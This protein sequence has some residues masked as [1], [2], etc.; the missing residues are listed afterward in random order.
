[1]RISRARTLA[2]L[3][4]DYGLSRRTLLRRLPSLL[5]A[6]AE[7]GGTN[8]VP[9]MWM[10]GKKWLVNVSLLRRSHPEAFEWPS[11]DELDHRVTR[12]ERQV[13]ALDA[14]HRA[15]VKRLESKT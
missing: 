2:E 6:D 13:E 15:L 14:A 3:A 5:R 8:F 4:E 12:L 11:T 9:W 1:M 10:V 7:K